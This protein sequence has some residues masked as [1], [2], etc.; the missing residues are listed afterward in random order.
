M[1]GDRDGAEPV[2][3]NTGRWVAAVVMLAVAPL[4]VSVGRVFLSA[5]GATPWT[6]SVVAVA[7]AATVACLVASAT[8]ARAATRSTAVPARDDGPAHEPGHPSGA[9][10]GHRPARHLAHDPARRMAEPSW[11]P[12]RR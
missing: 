4:P 7:T 6:A 12:R 11:Q 9:E 1:R 2:V 3:R 5:H 8:A 10:L